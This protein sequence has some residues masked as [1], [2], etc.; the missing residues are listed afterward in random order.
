MK[1]KIK[2]LIKSPKFVTALGA[3][4]VVIL[5][6]LGVASIDEETVTTALKLGLVILVGHS[7]TEAL[8]N[9]NNNIEEKV[10]NK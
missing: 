5:N 7:A 6:E 10:G 4:V 1:D 2:S 8:T 9:I 3:L